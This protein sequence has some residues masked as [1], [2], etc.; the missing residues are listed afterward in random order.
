ML[1][2]DPYRSETV[3]LTSEEFYA[4]GKQATEHLSPAA[5]AQHLRAFMGR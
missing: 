2:T 1:H 5:L 4:D 3:A